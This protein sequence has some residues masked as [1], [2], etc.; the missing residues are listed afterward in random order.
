MPSLLRR[1]GFSLAILLCTSSLALAQQSIAE[2]VRALNWQAGP[3]TAQLGSMAQIDVPE[4]FQFVGKPDAGK[5]MELIEN[6][7]DG[8]ELGLLLNTADGWFVVFEF[9]DD[10]YIKD[11]DRDFD[12]NG[13]LESIK[14]GTEAAN[15]IRRERGWSTMNI[16][17]WHQAPFYDPKTNN[18]TWS[19]K[20]ASDDSGET[21]NH[22][23]RLLGRR[24]VMK[25]ALVA[26]PE[27]I[28]VALPEFNG[29]MSTFS[30]TPGNRYS[31]FTRGDK[32]AEYG[33]AGLIAGGAGV[34]L[35]KTGVLQKF[36]KLIVVGFIAL[37]GM[38]KRALASLGGSRPAN[39]NV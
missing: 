29:M 18:L 9:S 28:D 8:S 2:Q 15:K 20:G 10:G 19:I 21:I 14:S 30:Y 35:V 34:A 12:A 26:S 5:F 25:V 11:D 16:V 6:P 31:E 23:T 38:V 36:W 37:A 32:I 33:L 39:Q 24:G 1:V 22:S 27:E 7:S 13:I 4:G 17:G 3:T